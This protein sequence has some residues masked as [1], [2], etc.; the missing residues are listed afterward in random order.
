MA[1]LSSKERRDI[2]EHYGYQGGGSLNR[3]FDRNSGARG[4]LKKRQGHVKSGRRSASDYHDRDRNDRDRG[5]NTRSSSTTSRSADTGPSPAKDT[6]VDAVVKKGNTRVERG[7]VLTT[8]E[9]RDI[10]QTYG[11][12]GKTTL[13]KFFNANQG[14]LGTLRK[15]QNQVQSGD[16]T[17]GQYI[18]NQ[19]PNEGG[20]NTLGNAERTEIAEFY[21]YQ[22]NGSLKDFY[23]RNDK[24]RG[25][26]E[27]RQGHVESGKRTASDFTQNRAFRE[28]N[29]L[30]GFERRDIAQHYGY[31]GKTNLINFFQNNSDAFGTLAKRRGQVEA[32]DRT[33]N[34]YLENNYPGRFETVTSRQNRRSN[35]RG[36]VDDAVNALPKGSA[37]PSPNFER[38]KNLNPGAQGGIRRRRLLG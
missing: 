7:N 37:R 12:S 2:A 27:K 31:E 25:T 23:A 8:G 6:G 29:V 5:R 30:S 20:F 10:A 16:R 34:Q 32:G 26:L 35:P 17:A 22:G 11:Y 1:T 9:R 14:A 36:P 19:Y 24:A 13:G 18:R 21:G 3:F 38:N 28:N 33:A 4:T 15:R